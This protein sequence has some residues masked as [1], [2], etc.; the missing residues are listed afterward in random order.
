MTK[1][2]DDF[3]GVLMDTVTGLYSGEITVENGTA[4]ANVAKQVNSSV[5]NDLRRVK[6]ETEGMKIPTIKLR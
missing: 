1:T 2:S 4:V 3:R 5:T 6:M